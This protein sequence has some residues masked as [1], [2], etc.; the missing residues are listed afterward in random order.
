MM[1]GDAY[2]ARAIDVACIIVAAAILIG[3]S[4]ML[5]VLLSK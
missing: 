2:T 5:I 1:Y 3:V 4:L